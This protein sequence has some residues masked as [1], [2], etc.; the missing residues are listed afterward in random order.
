[1]IVRILEEGQY[2]VPDD[3]LGALEA[4]DTKLSAAIDAD[5]DAG[6]SKGL[7]ELAGEI[8][9]RGT[10]LGAD[11]IVSSGLTIP[12]EGTSLE[13]V[14]RLLASGDAVEV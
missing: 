9:A 11:T 4:L 1:M 6:Y 10:A 2:E 5:D 3:E 13:E 12:H 8:R 7:S 14:K